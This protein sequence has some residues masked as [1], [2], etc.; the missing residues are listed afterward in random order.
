MFS[1]PQKNLEQF[2]L[3]PGY[4][5]ADLGSGSGFYTFTASK[6]V[7]DQSKFWYFFSRAHLFV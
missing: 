4:K 3:Q 2:V 5:V 7:G 1:D 6:M